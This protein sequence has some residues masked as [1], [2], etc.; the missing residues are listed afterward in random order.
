LRPTNRDRDV[1]RTP[2]GGAEI[3][4]EPAGPVAA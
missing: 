2:S 1:M 4:R 3:A